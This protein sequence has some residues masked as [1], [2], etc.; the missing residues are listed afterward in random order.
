MR[1]LLTGGSG[2]IGTQLC[3]NLLA[4]GNHVVVLSRHARQLSQ[5]PDIAV[6]AVATLTDLP[7]DY[8]P[9]VVINLAGAPIADL[10]WT[11]A[12]RQVLRDSRIRLTAELVAWLKTRPCLPQVVLS[13]SAVGYY[14]DGGELFLDETSIPAPGFAHDLCHAWEQEALHLEALG[15]RVCVMRFGIVLS[16]QG[17]FLARLKWPFLCGLGGRIGSGQQWFSWIHID[18]LIAAI[19]FLIVHQTLQGVFNLTAPMPVRNAEFTALLA[20]QLR[21][22]AVFPVPTVALRC[23]GEICTLFLDSQRVIPLRLQAA[24]FTFRFADLRLALADVL[25][26]A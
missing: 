1:Y 25:A 14:G 12:R 6:Q 4:A 17:G 16:R 5:R 21:R 26:K 22:P 9:E 11:A 8:C 2:L 7:A 19:G 13:A 20:Q 10:P 23:L 3:A 18:D 24:G 15:V